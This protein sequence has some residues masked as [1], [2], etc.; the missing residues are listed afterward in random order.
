MATVPF[1]DT[2][3]ELLT[4]IRDKGGFVNAHSHLDR[5][6]TVTRRSFALGGRT[7]REK[8][9]L[10][11][12]IKRRS[13]VPMIYDRM[14]YALEDQ[15]RQ[16]VT[17]IGS[18]IDIDEVIGDKAMKAAEKIRA[19]YGKQ[20]RIRY[21]NQTLKGV[22]D[23]HAREWF[24]EGAAFVDIIGGLPGKDEGREEEH[25]DFIIGEGRRLGK[26]VHVHV[27]QLN[28]AKE[29]ETLLL[30]KYVA[31]HHMA[32]KVVAVHGVSIA[33][34]PKRYREAL[35][36]EMKKTGMMLICCP[37]AWIDSR[38]TEVPA[39]SH[40]AIA[41]VEE[42]RAAGIPVALGSDNIFDI[43]KPFSDGDMR[44]ELRVLLESCHYYDI[45]DLVRIASEFG[46]KTLG[47]I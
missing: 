28:T 17:A 13:T 46:R 4:R 10:V 18:F 40:N 31:K 19:S 37:T 45:G 43:Y 41:P 8:W 42:L 32:G 21:I 33:A 27:D 1:F 6:Y 30:T 38:R 35:Y 29:E 14:A 25:L 20:I 15:I 34:H 36:A 44:T 16:G 47:L 12:D 5:A 22:L 24:L 23:P 11:D 39:P 2:K 9:A 26:M 3:A 7:L